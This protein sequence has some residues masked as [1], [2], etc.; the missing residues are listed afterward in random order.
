L[1]VNPPSFETSA[2]HRRRFDLDIGVDTATDSERP[3]ASNRVS[4]DNIGASTSRTRRVRRLLFLHARRFLRVPAWWVFAA[5]HLWERGTRPGGIS[6]GRFLA[7]RRV[8]TCVGI[9][10]PAASTS[11]RAWRCVM[12]ARRG[13]CGLV[14]G[15][16]LVL[17]SVPAPAH[18]IVPYGT[19]PSAGDVVIATKAKRLLHHTFL[20]QV[21]LVGWAPGGVAYTAGMGT[22]MPLVEGYAVFVAKNGSKAKVKKAG[23]GTLENWGAQVASLVRQY[24][25]KKGDV[26]QDVTVTPRKMLGTA[27]FKTKPSPIGPYHKA[28]FKITMRFQAIVTIEGGKPKKGIVTVV[29][30]TK[31]VRLGLPGGD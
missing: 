17:S 1:E 22:G 10:V 24:R 21:L 19:Y 16:A 6:A 25:E 20:G 7:H 31:G 11:A 28:S 18:E 2:C 3:F 29:V 9:C 26:V 13:V 23:P 30:T 4:A 27:T 5:L 8:E 15:L 14:A 12:N